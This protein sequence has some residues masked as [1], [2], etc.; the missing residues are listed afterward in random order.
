MN[1]KIL[2][3]I[4]TL[5]IIGLLSVNVYAHRAYNDD[6]VKYDVKKIDNGVQYTITSEDKEVVKELQ[7]DADSWAKGSGRGFFCQGYD[8]RGGHMMDMGGYGYGRRYHHGW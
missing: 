8:G 2:F 7:E 3:W 4:V 5:G 1:K 6:Q